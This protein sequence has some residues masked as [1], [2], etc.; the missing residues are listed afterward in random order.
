M[1]L[2]LQKDP[3]KRYSASQLLQHEFINNIDDEICRLELSGYILEMK[4][5]NKQNK[6]I[7]D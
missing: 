2:C 5:I 6:I 7:T 3:I 4:R 1:D